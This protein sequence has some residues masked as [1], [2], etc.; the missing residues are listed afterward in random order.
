MSVMFPSGFCC[1]WA[2]CLQSSCWFSG[3]NPLQGTSWPM[4]LWGRPLSQCECMYIFAYFY[5]LQSICQFSKTEQRPFKTWFSDPL[6]TSP[7]AESP[8]RHSTACACGSSWRCVRCGLRWL[9]TTCRPTSIWLRSGWSRWRRRQD[10]SQRLTF[11]ERSAVWTERSLFD[12]AS[13][14]W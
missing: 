2:S 7:L 6:I 8:A 5:P 11:R 9:V 1:T 12:W 13:E 10:A 3:W 14:K 4:H